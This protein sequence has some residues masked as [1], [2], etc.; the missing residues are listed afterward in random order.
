MFVEELENCAEIIG[1]QELLL[2]LEKPQKSLSIKFGMD[3]TAPDLHLGH[4]VV[5]NQLRRFQEA[6]HL[7]KIVI[8]DF[9]AMIG[10]PSGKNALRPML[11]R[12]EVL[13]NAETYQKQIFK[14]LRS[15]RTEI[16]FNSAWLGKFSTIDLLKLS[17]KYTVARM[18]ERDDFE[19][20]YRHQTPIAICE[21]LYPLLQGYDSVALRSDVEIGGNDQKFNLLVGRELQKRYEQKPQIVITM[22]LLE[23]LDG[24]KKMSKS[25]GNYVGI[26]EEPKVMF[27]KLMSISDVLMWR[28][29]SLLSFKSKQEIAALKKQVQLN[30]NPRDVKFDLA[31]ELVERFYDRQTAL[32]AKQAFIDQFQK[33][34]LPEL[35]PEQTLTVDAEVKLVQALK[36][37]QL[38]ESLSAARRLIQQ[39]GVKL[40]GIKVTDINLTLSNQR[41]YLIQ[42]GKH[43]F[44]RL[45]L[46]EQN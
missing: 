4:T 34:Q 37:T 21:F 43:K 17:A 29:L 20:R 39:G 22:P 38:T 25:L 27:G 36:L 2:A 9:T 5:L 35:I 23:G 19:N 44:L 16:Y 10:D 12:E 7:V 3:P 28:Y 30:L 40:D 45:K 24:E 41:N 31:L 42:C 6:G 15:D 26:D 13:K 46:K 1:K 33:Q 8:G 14:I 11:T 32:D 18:L